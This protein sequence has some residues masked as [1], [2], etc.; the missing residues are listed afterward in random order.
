MQIEEGRIFELDNKEFV[1]V[2]SIKMNNKNYVNMV[3][4]SKPVEF[5]IAQ[6]DEIGENFMF[7]EIEDQEELKMVLQEISKESL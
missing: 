1:V 5:I 6:V 7:S 4:N 3:S 2:N